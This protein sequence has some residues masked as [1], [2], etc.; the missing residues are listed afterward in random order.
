MRQRTYDILSFVAGSA[1]FVGLA[2][3][4]ISLIIWLLSIP[5]A[6]TQ[7]SYN[8]AADYRYE[9][10]VG[11]NVMWSDM[12]EEFGYLDTAT[13]VYDF[14]DSWGNYIDRQCFDIHLPV[15]IHDKFD[16]GKGQ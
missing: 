13:C 1:V 4:V 15:V 10:H 7:G 11:P 3:G 8:Y 14:H 16:Q 12:P 5:N 6:P 9:I 2:V